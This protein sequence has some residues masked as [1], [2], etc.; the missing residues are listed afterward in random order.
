[1]P[2]C[3]SPTSLAPPRDACPRRPPSSCWS[4]SSPRC[5]ECPR[6]GSREL[7]LPR[8]ALPALRSGARPRAHPV[9]CPA[10]GALALR[11]P[12][13]V[14]CPASSTP[15]PAHGGPASSPSWPSATERVPVSAVQRRGWG[16]SAASDLGAAYNVPMALGGWRGELDAG[17][18]S[19]AVHDVVRRHEPRTLFPSTTAPVPARRRPISCGCRCRRRRHPADLQGEIERAIRTPFHLAHDLPCGPACCA[20]RRRARARGSRCTISPA[21]RLAA[22]PDPRPRRRLRGRSAGHDPDWDHWGCSRPTLTLWQHDLLAQP[23]DGGTR[24]TAQLAFWQDTLAGIP[25]RLQLPT[26]RPG[27]PRAA[28]PPQRRAR[29]L[30]RAACAPRALARR[31]DVSLAMVLQG[32]S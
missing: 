24:E 8:W 7:L 31:H 6:S 3:P 2:P 23:V 29:G 16:F 22:A 5:S 9:R 1:M 11:R 10:A 19:D 15:P 12:H 21:T 20:P 13:R 32:P 14:P 25:D 17:A 27:R 30:P 26:D 28:S 18:L 4:T